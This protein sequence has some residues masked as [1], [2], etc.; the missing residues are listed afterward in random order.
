MKTIIAAIVIVMFAGSANAQNGVSGS[1]AT[2]ESTQARPLQATGESADP[3]GFQKVLAISQAAERT[4]LASALPAL[5]EKMVAEQGTG[6]TEELRSKHVLN[7]GMNAGSGSNALQQRSIN[8]HVT[9]D[10]RPVG[11]IL[12]IRVELVPV[13]GGIGSAVRPTVSRE[14]AQAVD[15]FDDDFIAQTIV[16]LTDELATEYAAK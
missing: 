8:V 16:K 3:L 4:T 5:A 13:F 14:F 15:D 9:Y 1:I 11:G 7:M 6:A 12:N 10:A 2:S